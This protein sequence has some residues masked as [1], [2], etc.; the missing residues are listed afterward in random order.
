MRDQQSLYDAAYSSAAM[1]GVT[2]ELRL[3]K[4]NQK[5]FSPISGLR[6]ELNGRKSTKLI[7]APSK[8]QKICE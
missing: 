8:I 1:S 3:K 7:L 4:R 2:P 6:A 5:P